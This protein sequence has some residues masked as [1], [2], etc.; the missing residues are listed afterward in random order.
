MQ[1]LFNRAQDVNR[2][3]E[4]WEFFTGN[5]K[6]PQKPVIVIHTVKITVVGDPVKGDGVV[7]GR[8][9]SGEPEVNIVFRLQEFKGLAV[10]Q[11]ACHH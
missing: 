9:A 5:V 4:I 7:R 8:K 3:L 1:L 2:P 11:T 10:L 6:Y